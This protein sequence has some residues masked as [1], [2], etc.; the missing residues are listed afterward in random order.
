MPATCRWTRRRRVWRGRALPV[1]LRKVDVDGD[2]LFEVPLD[3]CVLVAVAVV[4]VAVGQV[5]KVRE[6]TASAV[7]RNGYQAELARLRIFDDPCS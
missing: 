7:S 5:L 3:G 4:V 6:E 1:Q 2:A